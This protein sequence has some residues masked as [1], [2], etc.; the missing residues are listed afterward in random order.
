M[1]SVDEF[2]DKGSYVV[3]KMTQED[4]NKVY[5]QAY[6]KLKELLGEGKTV[7]FDGGSLRKSERQTLKNIVESMNILSKLIYVNT[8]KE[9]II[10]RRTEN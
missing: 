5:S 10:K 7:I 2:L 6:K 4:W 9:E 3:E 1:A 8:T